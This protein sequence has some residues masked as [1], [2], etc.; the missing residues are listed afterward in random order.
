MKVRHPRVE[1]L[2]HGRMDALPEIALFARYP[3]PGAAKTRLIPALG[4]EQAAQTHRLL[5]E[6]TL[7][8]MRKGNLPFRLHFT[9]A[10]ASDFAAWLGDDVPLVEQGEGGLG[11]RMA[12]VPAPA[13][14]LGS[15]IPDLTPRHLREAADA[16]ASHDLVVGPA[17]DGG[18]YLLGFKVPVHFLFEDMEWGTET[19]LAITLRRAR[20]RGMSVA[21]LEVLADC[22]RPADLSQWPDLL[23]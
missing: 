13:I 20:A 7:A 10:K 6:R 11:E 18:Y 1:R 5:V 22:D 19:V 23:P 3:E 12:R 8:T 2:K 15:D 4:P 9:G 16:L 14:L 17:K 21:M